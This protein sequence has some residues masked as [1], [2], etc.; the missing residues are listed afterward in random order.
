MHNA[1]LTKGS[2]HE[3][4]NKISSVA[5]RIKMFLLLSKEMSPKSKTLSKLRI[6]FLYY[7]Y[8]NIFYGVKKGYFPKQWKRALI[9]KNYRPISLFEIFGKVLERL[10]YNSMF[11]MFSRITLSLLI[12]PVLRLVTR[13]S[14]NLSITHKIYKSFDDAYK[15][16]GVYLNI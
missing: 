7:G 8:V 12:S 5:S 13:A 11:S 4:L 2:Q 16:R 10:L 14:T 6:T 15:V 1:M 3:L 9:P